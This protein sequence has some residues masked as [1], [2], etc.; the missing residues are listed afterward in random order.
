MVQKR[1]FKYTSRCNRWRVDKIGEITWDEENTYFYL[2]LSYPYG[3]EVAFRGNLSNPIFFK[4]NKDPLSFLNQKMNGKVMFT[5]LDIDKCEI[6]DVLF[7]VKKDDSCNIFVLN[8]EDAYNA[9]EQV[10]VVDT[11]VKKFTCNVIEDPSEKK[12]IIE[13]KNTD[14]ENEKDKSYVFMNNRGECVAAIIITENKLTFM[15]VF[16]QS[17]GITRVNMKL[18][19][20]WVDNINIDMDNKSK[21]I[22]DSLSN[23]RKYF[24]EASDDANNRFN[25]IALTDGGARVEMIMFD[26]ID[27]IEKDI[28]EQIDDLRVDN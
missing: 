19:K 28:S 14:Y 8:L 15:T 24:I 5:A 22:A 9:D 7:R 20:V 6:V 10:E 25:I 1:V 27:V 21:L 18:D 11:L 17:D 2:E 4:D 26:R 12:E 23:G 13:Q 16:K 3:T